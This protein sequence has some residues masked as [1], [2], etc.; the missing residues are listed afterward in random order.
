MDEKK[1][2]DH[3]VEGK[4]DEKLIEAF[5]EKLNDYQKYLKKEEETIDTV[6]VNKLIDYTEDLVKKDEKAVL[7]FLRAFI[8]Y[9]YFAKRNDIVEACIDIFESFNAM[10]NLY[11][12]IGEWHGEETRDDI[13]KDLTIPPLGVHPEKKPEFTKI[14]LKRAEEKLGEDKVI[15]LLKPCLHGGLGGDMEQDRKDYHVLGIDAFLE[16]KRQEKVKEFE[17]HRDNGTPAFAQIV[18]DSVVESVKNNKTA[19]L[20]KRE[21]NFLLVTKNPYQ[22]K[23]SLETDDVRMKRF[24]AC[25]CP[26]VRGA[27]KDGTEKDVSQH[28]CQCSGGWYKDYYEQLFEQPIRI[29]PYETALNGYTSCTF[30]VYLPENVIIK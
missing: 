28:F 4:V 19:A 11:A 18:D 26:W 12:R 17:K 22:V 8:T 6:D 9:A 14:V 13:F 15:A 23:K 29:E 16:K 20:G 24:Y 3:L 21:G 5:I 27:I 30:K 7:I 25:F 1:F 10:D 2:R